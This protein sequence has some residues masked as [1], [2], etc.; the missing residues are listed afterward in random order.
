MTSTPTDFDLS[1]RVAVVTKLLA[2]NHM[3]PIP[4]TVTGEV[5]GTMDLDARGDLLAMDLDIKLPSEG[6]TFDI[7]KR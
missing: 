6:G 1:G 7:V 4:Q 2:I 3:K 5:V